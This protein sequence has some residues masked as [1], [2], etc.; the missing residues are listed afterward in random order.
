MAPAGVTFGHV[1]IV[2]R[3]WR[4]LSR[5]Y[6][7]VF[8]CVPV[9]PRRKLSGAWLEAGTAVKGAALEGEHLRLPGH[10]PE[11]PTLEIY[12]YTRSHERPK[13][14]ANRLGLGHVAFRV[15]DVTETLSR[16]LAE[17]GRALGVVSSAEV[18]GKGPLAFVYACDPEDN[19][20]ELQSWGASGLDERP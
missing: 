16:V 14:A 3:D 20:I 10:G 12:S 6:R 7:D 5:F 19:I 2:A 13:A 8:G 1:N 11:G 18:P 15:P 17:G 4:R 9:P